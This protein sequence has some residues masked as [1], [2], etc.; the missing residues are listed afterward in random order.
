MSTRYFKDEPVTTH[1]QTCGRFPQAIDRDP[2]ILIFHT[3]NGYRGGYI[4]NQIQDFCE[5]VLIKDEFGNDSYDRVTLPLTAVV[6]PRRLNNKTIYIKINQP[7]AKGYIRAGYNIEIGQGL[8]SGIN[9]CQSKSN[10]KYPIYQPLTFHNEHH[11]NTLTSASSFIFQVIDDYLH[12]KTFSPQLVEQA[13]WLVNVALLIDNYPPL[14]QA[15]FLEALTNFCWDYLC[16]SSGTLLRQPINYILDI[17]QID[18]VYQKG[19]LSISYIPTDF[20]GIHYQ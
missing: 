17:L 10:D 6:R 11:R 16:F 12:G 8:G 5:A 1:I 19:G 4:I 9:S 3:Q 14:N 13:R 18:G 2:A 7:R 20:E 15:V